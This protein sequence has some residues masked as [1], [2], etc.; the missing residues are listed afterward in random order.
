[1]VAV[2][3]YHSYKFDIIVKNEYTDENIFDNNKDDNN[4]KLENQI[5]YEKIIKVY[6]MFR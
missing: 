2:V 4:N 3:R 5:F 6:A 1:M